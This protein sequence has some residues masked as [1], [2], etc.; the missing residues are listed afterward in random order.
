MGI[1]LAQKTF[2][3]YIGAT[4]PLSDAVRSAI[5]NA[6][7]DGSMSD[8]I[9]VCVRS[10][11]KFG[12]EYVTKLRNMVARHMSRPYVFVCLTDMMDRCEGMVF[13]S[14]K[15]IG[16]HGWWCKFLV[17]EPAWRAS[18]QI[19]YLD[20]DTVVIGDLAQ[21]ADVPHEFAI[22]ESPVRTH[23]IKSYPCKFNSSVMTIAGGRCGFMWERF[24]RRRSTMMLE[25]D[26]YGDQKA[27]EEL[28]PDAAILNRLMP[29]GFFVNYRDL[30]SHKPKEASVVNF[31]G[32]SKPHSCPIPWVQAEWQ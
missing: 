5:A 17:F 22:L 11:T 23:G 21:L 13:V 9:V 24:D 7:G 18:S 14:I 26:R 29:K 10:G 1:R 31:G 19:I 15:E 4:E 20:L 2:R 32:P 27:I 30:T 12:F 25:H 8:L 16:L 3:L 28:Y 6:I